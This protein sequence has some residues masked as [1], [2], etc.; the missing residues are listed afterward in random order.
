MLLE[1]LKTKRIL[2]LISLAML[3]CSS[4]QATDRY[5]SKLGI[6]M[7]GVRT[8]Q[9]SDIGWLV[10]AKAV[11][12]IGKSKAYWGITGFWGSPSGQSPG[13]DYMFYGGLNLGFEGR[14]TK[15]LLY[16]FN[17]TA[18]YGQGNFRSA[19]IGQSSFFVLEPN[20]GTGF[21]LGLG[22]R[23]LFNVGYINMANAPNF[24]GVVLG[25]RLE[26]ATETVTKPYER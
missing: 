26:I 18:G 20:F 13:D 19:N 12:Y 22:W 1:R 3:I 14:F 16:D 23:I 15:N 5:R 10:G 17:L 6:D 21:Y 9:L 7:R 11:Q 2:G 24:S 8:N 4:G 25:F